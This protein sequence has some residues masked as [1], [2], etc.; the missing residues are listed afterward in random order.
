MNFKLISR[1]SIVF[2]VLAI[3]LVFSMSVGMAA[4]DRPEV[5]AVS[6]VSVTSNSGASDTAD[7][8]HIQFSKDMIPETI[9]TQTILVQDRSTLEALSGTVS[10]NNREAVFRLNDDGYNLQQEGNE[11]LVIVTAEVSDTRGNSLANDAVWQILTTQQTT[12]PQTTLQATPIAAQQLAAPSQQNEAV[13]QPVQTAR[14]FPYAV[15]IIALL[16]LTIIV[17]A[18]ASKNKKKVFVNKNPFGLIHPVS[19]LEGI[20][21]VYTKKLADVGIQN[22][23]QLWQAHTQSLALKIGLD[24]KTVQNWQQMAELTA[25]HG[26][27][28]QY[29]ELLERSG[30]V[31]I[32]QLANKNASV[33]LRKIKRTQNALKIN[34]QGNTIGKDI[35]SSW[36]A[37]A[38]K[39]AY[40]K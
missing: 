29:A 30:I 1:A 11:F 2:T 23:K 3:M 8:I 35:V 24:A 5:T 18:L 13:N 6:V 14:S 15:A 12:A 33:L 32:A 37:E 19:Y 34:I 25:I 40:T 27:G 7:R 21:S 4:T 36:I 31:S 16:L 9:N 17:A 10:Y 22:T 20:G 39:H 28:P 26:V 38:S